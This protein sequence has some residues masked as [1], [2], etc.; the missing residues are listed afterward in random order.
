[1]AIRSYKPTSP[2]RRFQTVQDYSEITTQRPYKPLTE[3]LKWKQRELRGP[4]VSEEAVLLAASG[5]EGSVSPA[6][7]SG[8]NG[9]NGPPL[10]RSAGADRPLPRGER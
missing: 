1:M 5:A 10:T 6:S 2:G 7:S 9:A 8:P 4:E 3:T